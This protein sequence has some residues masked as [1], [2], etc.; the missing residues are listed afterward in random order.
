MLWLRK[1]IEEIP[2]WI[3]TSIITSNSLSCFISTKFQGILIKW[4]AKIFINTKNTH[5]F[6]DSFSVD[7]KANFSKDFE[8]FLWKRKKIELLVKSIEGVWPEREKKLIKVA[9]HAIEIAG[10]RATSN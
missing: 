2:R 1:Q 9:S 6:K 8:K 5:R 3:S 7:D 4:T 10:K